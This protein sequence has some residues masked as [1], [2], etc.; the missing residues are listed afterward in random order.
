M[1]ASSSN[2]KPPAPIWFTLDGAKHN[3]IQHKPGIT[4]TAAN[5][6]IN[7]ISDVPLVQDVITLTEERSREI[8]LGT[9][10]ISDILYEDEIILL[11]QL[12]LDVAKRLF[13]TFQRSQSVK[14]VYMLFSLRKMSGT[15]NRWLTWFRS[16]FLADKTFVNHYKVRVFGIDGFIK[17]A[18]P[19]PSGQSFITEKSY[20][21]LEFN[22]HPKNWSPSF[23]DKYFSVKSAQGIEFN[24]D[25]PMYILDFP[26]DIHTEEPLL[27]LFDTLY[28]RDSE[29]YPHI[30]DEPSIGSTKACPRKAL[31]FSMPP[32][33]FR[34]IEDRLRDEY[35]QALIGIP[36]IDAKKG[37]IPL[38]FRTIEGAM[39]VLDHTPDCLY[40]AFITPKAL[41]L[42]MK[43]STKSD[44]QGTIDRLAPANAINPVYPV[45]P[46][47]E[48]KQAATEPLV[49]VEGMLAKWPVT[50]TKAV[51]T[52]YCSTA[53]P[54][55]TPLEYARYH[56]QKGLGTNSILLKVDSLKSALALVAHGD[57]VMTDPSTG[58]S[59]NIRFSLIREGTYEALPLLK[60]VF[61]SIMSDGENKTPSAPVITDHCSRL[62]KNEKDVLTSYRLISNEEL[63]AGHTATI[64]GSTAGNLFFKSVDFTDYQDIFQCLIQHVDTQGRV[65]RDKHGQKK[66]ALL[67]YD[68]ALVYQYGNQPDLH[69]A[70]IR[71]IPKVEDIFAYITHLLG[72][73][74]PSV[75][76]TDL[77][78]IY[79]VSYINA[80][81]GEHSDNER[82]IMKD[83]HIVTVSVGKSRNFFSSTYKIRVPTSEDLDQATVM[84]WPSNDLHKHGVLPPVAESEKG[85]RVVFSFRAMSSKAN[86]PE[87]FS[88]NTPPRG[89]KVRA[90][91]TEGP[92]RPGKKVRLEDLG[93]TRRRLA[94]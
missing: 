23:K 21:V 84:A 62:S 75:S 9:D 93:P 70:N 80:G 14:A 32:D 73:E 37:M 92:S 22:L 71:T 72:T 18:I 49:K 13:N 61:F 83:S 85:T 77:N 30:I 69:A 25:P 6:L 41:C 88:L 38:F 2:R 60:P 54:Q 3:L 65:E 76:N 39:A 19:L 10:D 58:S 7:R 15:P 29:Q 81:V 27:D 31:T 12:Q 20:A 64:P 26:S 55:A 63:E 16:A 51:I 47:A 74:V 66:V 8:V 28:E 43:D 52:Q 86:D 5:T 46:Y 57:T 40:A 79:I 33:D 24:F 44:I 90:P 42:I 89:R 59:A 78:T 17:T 68:A 82:T 45:I 36:N 53:D 34:T 11:P 1:E 56:N 4:I 48:K 35:P 94:Y 67:S 91:S 87:Y 50:T